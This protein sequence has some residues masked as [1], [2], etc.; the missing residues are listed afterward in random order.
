[1]ST[2]TEVNKPLGDCTL[3]EIYYNPHGDILFLLDN[4]N[5]SSNAESMIVKSVD[6]KRQNFN[7]YYK[8]K[9]NP[10]IISFSREIRGSRDVVILRCDGKFRYGKNNHT[11]PDYTNDQNVYNNPDY[12]SYCWDAQYFEKVINDESKYNVNINLQPHPGLYRDTLFPHIGK[13]ISPPISRTFDFGHIPIRF[14]DFDENNNNTQ[15]DSNYSNT[16]QQYEPMEIENTA[17]DQQ[18]VKPS[19]S[20]LKTPENQNYPPEPPTQQPGSRD[21][22][23]LNRTYD[24]PFTENRRLDFTFGSETKFNKPLLERVWNNNSNIRAND[25]LER[26]QLEQ[27]DEEDE[28]EQDFG[29]VLDRELRKIRKEQERKQQQRELERQQKEQERQQ[30]EQE[31]QQK[32]ELERQARKEY[33]QQR[34]TNRKEYQQQR[35]QLRQEYED[36][37]NQLQQEHKRKKSTKSKNNINELAKFSWS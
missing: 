17:E 29:K 28:D 20:I 33:L 7:Y 4:I 30:R 8:I 11:I 24:T 25:R 2:W 9:N 1:M 35:T 3:L 18:Q 31:R 37:Q 6:L 23:H 15:N 10:T 26:M 32:R 27:Q 14:A 16:E 34:A 22:M 12:G 19:E 5:F 13:N 21:E 36:Q